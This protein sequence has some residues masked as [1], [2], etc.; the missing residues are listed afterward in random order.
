MLKLMALGD[1]SLKT[2]KDRHPFE[3]IKE[4]LCNKDLLFGNLETVLSIQ[5]KKEEKSYL[6][7]SPSENVQYLL[8]AGFDILNIANNHIMDLGVEGFDETLDVLTQNNL[9]FIGA[10][11]QKYRQ[12]W[13]IIERNDVKIGFLGYSNSSIK[14]KDGHFVNGIEQKTIISDIQN[15]KKQCDVVIISL[16]WGIEKVFYP[17]PKQ[18]DLARNLIENGATI[19]LGHH[20]HVIQ[21][22]EEYK[23]GIIAYSLGNF[24]FPFNHEECKGTK[25]KRTNQ[26]I[27]LSLDIG[28]NSLDSYEILP[29]KIDKD[30]I[31][32]IMV[33]EE[34]QEM[35]D[36]LSE[37]SS[38]IIDNKL[39]WN[40]WFEEI[41]LE[42][43]SGNM[44]SWI[45]R[46]RRYGIMH[47]IQ[48]VKWLICPFVI[49]C[50]LG[51]IS[52]IMKSVVSNR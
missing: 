46:I 23:H 12:H 50:Y 10:G 25:S 49:R 48:C 24:Q 38:P 14:T 17:S 42:Y 29:V 26:S 13:V 7:C 41:A 28:K 52:R 34:R 1:I 6:S 45:I 2:I 35:M 21:G 37:I 11:N 9:L 20:P 36:F 19:I 15:L 33:D 8:E 44:K 40:T 51:I 39:T 16:H 30:F 31:P 47:F 32:S 4:F 43:L 18:I 5:G 27:V 22:I 3:N